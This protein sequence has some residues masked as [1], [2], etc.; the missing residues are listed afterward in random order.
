MMS[1][2]IIEMVNIIPLPHSF[3]VE[4]KKNMPLTTTH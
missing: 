2:M 1:R 3:S 4:L